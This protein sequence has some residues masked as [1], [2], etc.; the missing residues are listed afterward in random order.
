MVAIEDSKTKY[1]EKL[2]DKILNVKLGGK[3]Y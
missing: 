3:C 2:S 1:Y